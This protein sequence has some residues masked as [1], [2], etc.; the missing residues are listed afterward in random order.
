MRD[1]LL[2][3]RLGQ[4][5]ATVSET[6]LNR[7]VELKGK[8]LTR[9]SELDFNPFWD[10]HRNTLIRDYMRPPRG[11]EFKI[12]VLEAKLQYNICLVRMPRAPIYLPI[13]QGKVI[14]FFLRKA[15]SPAVFFDRNSLF[16]PSV[17]ID[18]L[19]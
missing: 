7:I 1:R 6:E 3:H 11:G 15:Q 10:Q 8:I 2:V 18:S 4:R 13:R 9:M 17:E 19:F 5:N 16:H 12:S 14:Q